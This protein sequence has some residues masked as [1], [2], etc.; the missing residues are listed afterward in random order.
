MECHHKI[1]MISKNGLKIESYKKIILVVL[2]AST[3]SSKAQEF[4]VLWSSFQ[5][6]KD[7]SKNISINIKPIFRFNEDISRYQNMSIDYFVKYKFKK[8]WSTQALGR[9]WFLPNV[10]NRQFIWF[11]VA[12][13]K[14]FKRLKIDNKLRYHWALDINDRS[15]P[16]YLR[17][18]TKFSLKNKSKF[19]PYIAIE[20]WFRTNGQNQLRRIRFEPGVIGVLNK[21]ISFNLQYRREE[22]LN[23][24]RKLIRNFIVFNLLYKI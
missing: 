9:T 1:F 21:A 6:Q 7:I 3:F 22:T 16:D 24:N 10:P 18:S 2:L 4:N 19:T 14:T 5:V 15:D 20:P 17:W 13:S 11:D 12:L 23:L 8:G